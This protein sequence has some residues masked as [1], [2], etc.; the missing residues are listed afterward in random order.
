MSSGEKWREH[1]QTIQNLGPTF[2]HCDGFTLDGYPSEAL[3]RLHVQMAWW[4]LHVQ[5]SKECLD[6]RSVWHH[7][8]YS[9][10]AIKRNFPS[11][12]L[13]NPRIYS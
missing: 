3:Q 9:Y 4:L 12:L 8:D 6:R 11:G 5:P 13:E 10:L 7:C 1:L 2:E